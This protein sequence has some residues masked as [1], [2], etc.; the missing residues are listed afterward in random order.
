M[1]LVPV[2]TVKTIMQV[3]GKGGVSTLRA[4][5][6]KNGPTALFHGA[7]ASA[8]ATFA[9]HYP[10]Y[11]TLLLHAQRIGVGALFQFATP[12]ACAYPSHRL[13][14]TSLNALQVRNVQHVAAKDPQARELLW[15]AA[16]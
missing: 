5:V 1:L 12:P 11:A 9:G 2:D 16:A 8:A 14:S 3:E 13:S 4:K 7:V 15:Q 6:A 10:W